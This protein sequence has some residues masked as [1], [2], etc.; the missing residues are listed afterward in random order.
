M[1]NVIAVIV[2]SA[3]ALFASTARLHAGLPVAEQRI[4]WSELR[5]AK[6]KSGAVRI[7]TWSFIDDIPVIKR[8]HTVSTA[9][10][11]LA[12]VIKLENGQK[13]IYGD[14]RVQAALSKQA[15]EKGLKGRDLANL[16]EQLNKHN[17]GIEEEYEKAK[18]GRGKFLTRGVDFSRLIEKYLSDNQG[19]IAAAIDAFAAKRGYAAEIIVKANPSFDYL[20]ETIA[21]KEPVVLQ[22]IGTDTCIV[23]IGF[24]SRNGDQYIITVNPDTVSFEE[25]SNADLVLGEGKMAKHAREKAKEYDRKYGLAKLDRKVQLAGDMPS[26]VEIIKWRPGFY[27]AITIDLAVSEQSVN[28]AFP[29]SM[30]GLQ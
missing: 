4:L 28:R 17:A 5:D 21:R 19:D 24:L 15:R 9:A 27:A 25:V 13:F 8:T 2:I 26:G 16:K 29:S 30:G 12:T 22:Q 18:K 10:A 7:D 20:A 11:A 6:N 23:C 14:E 1:R 3:L